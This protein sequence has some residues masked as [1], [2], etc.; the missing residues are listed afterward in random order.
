[1]AKTQTRKHN[2]VDINNLSQKDQDILSL[3][4]ATVMKKYKME[5]Q[6]VYDKRYA[7][8]KKAKQ[9]GSTIPTP[10]PTAIAQKKR[11]PKKGQKRKVQPAA[12][13]AEKVEPAT[14]TVVSESRELM[15]VNKQLPVIHKPIEINFAN[16]SVKL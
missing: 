16:F 15:V 10:V 4:T 13:A 3:D 6:A 12:L 14:E 8:K 11:G 1:M 2:P 9:A 5:K 7:L